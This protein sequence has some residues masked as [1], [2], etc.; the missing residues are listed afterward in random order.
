MII[1]FTL[2]YVK[3]QENNNVYAIVIK[4]MQ[5]LLIISIIKTQKQVLDKSV[6][7]MYNN[8]IP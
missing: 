8:H 4:F 3:C 7:P 1:I 5:W 2:C 6:M